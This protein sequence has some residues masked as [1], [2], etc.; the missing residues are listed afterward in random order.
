MKAIKLLCLIACE[1][2]FLAEKKFSASIM[3]VAPEENGCVHTII[4]PCILLFDQENIFAD[5]FN[6]LEQKF[7]LGGLN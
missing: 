2:C 1:S 6:W 3:Q 7:Q 5:C 4:T